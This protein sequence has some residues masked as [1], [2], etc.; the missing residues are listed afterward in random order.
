MKKKRFNQPLPL[1]LLAAVLFAGLAF[2]TLSAQIPSFPG[3]EGFGATAV[4]G[5]GGQ[6]IFV[7]NTNLSG[8]GS[9]QEALDTP[10]ARYILFRCSGVIDGTVEIPVGASNITIAGQTSPNGII[11][12]GLSAYNDQGTSATSVIIRHL[13]SRCGDPDLFPTSN[14]LSGDGITLGGANQVIVDHCSF[15]HNLD[16]AVDISR[17]SNITIQNCI[18]NETL[19]EHYDRGGMLL[20]YSS[21]SNPI[22][23]ISIHHN[24]WSRIGGRFPEF[25]C[26]SPECNNHTL[27][28]ELASNLY[29]DPELEVYYNSS[30]NPGGGTDT[31]YTNLNI[32]ENYYM[33]QPGY[34]NGMFLFQLL[35]IAQNDLYVSGNRVSIYPNWT[36]F[37]LFS[38]C[39][40]FCTTGPNTD[41]GVATH[42]PNRH[43]YPQV[44]YT[45]STQL[46]SHMVANVGAFPRDAQDQRILGYINNGTFLSQANS[47]PGA[48][49]AFQI[50]N[51]T[52]GV[53]PD[54][55]NEGMP[56][57][58]E[59][60]HGLNPNLA[61]HNGQ[62]LSVA[63]TGVAGYTNLEC[64]LNCLAD[65]LVNGTS[66]QCGIAIG[67]D[68]PK[69][70]QPLFTA[71]PNPA[72]GQIRV[73]TDAHAKGNL[74]L[75]DIHGK[76]LRQFPI[77]ASGNHVL[78]ISQLPTGIYLLRLGHTTQKIIV[79]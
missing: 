58:W 63:I 33:P 56:D 41:P 42:L 10:G 23:N 44:T 57:Y 54:A 60:L 14:W 35:N 64:Y 24:T 77:S 40:D 47:I 5:R 20:N 2:Q 75:L 32:V 31:Y 39:N 19:G 49:D 21:N 36:D 66:P 7:T 38:C 30:I 28:G 25:S 16:E 37:Q 15:G 4:G 52:A 3:A 1:L 55:D 78:D 29:Y 74:E 17:A 22:D 53:L 46:R 50:T 71:Y 34:C 62:N 48:N 59:N 79:N 76:I 13:R 8:P 72:H 61:D 18:L 68:D 27:H 65:A 51:S 11:V 12:R 69:V 43:A 67:V 70:R 6:V 9:L 26:E 73:E 45:P